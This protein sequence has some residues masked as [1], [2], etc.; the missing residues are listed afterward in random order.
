MDLLDSIRQMVFFALIEGFLHE[1]IDSRA[2]DGVI[3]HHCGGDLIP[4]PDLGKQAADRGAVFQRGIGTLRHIGQ[5]RMSTVSPIFVESAWFS[6]IPRLG[7]GNL[8]LQKGP[9][10]RISRTE[11]ARLSTSDSVGNSCVE[12]EFA[13]R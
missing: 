4:T 5:H 9:R 8:R 11:G 2:T 12:M 13:L 7:H 3:H 1:L 6:S 10:G